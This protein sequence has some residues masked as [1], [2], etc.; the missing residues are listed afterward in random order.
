M[1]PQATRGMAYH[2]KRETNNL[3]WRIAVACRYD[4]CSRNTYVQ[5]FSRGLRSSAVTEAVTLPLTFGSD[6]T[7]AHMSV[8]KSPWSGLQRSFSRIIRAALLEKFHAWS[9]L[10]LLLVIFLPPSS[11]LFNLQPFVLSQCTLLCLLFGNKI[12]A[13]QGFCR[14]FFQK[15]KERNSINP[16]WCHLFLL[17]MSHGDQLGQAP[18]AVHKN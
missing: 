18:K 10:H 16:L 17:H 3:I 7:K 13:T 1:P 15:R 6:G 14:S 5:C 8:T 11:W 4:L 2:T 9:A 12:Q